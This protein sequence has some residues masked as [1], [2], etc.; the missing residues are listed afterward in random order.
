MLIYDAVAPDFVVY[1]EKCC[2]SL[3]A[4]SVVCKRDDYW[5]DQEE[6]RKNARFIN[7]SSRTTAS[8]LSGV[9]AKKGFCIWP[10]AGSGTWA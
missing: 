4:G 3:Q 1:R 9:C 2:A 6:A 10:I 8:A 5:L 7:G